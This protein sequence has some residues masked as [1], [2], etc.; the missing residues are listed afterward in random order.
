[1]NKIYSSPVRVCLCAG[2]LILAGIW[3]FFNLPVAMFPDSTRPMIYVN[4][5]F[6]SLPRE[7]FLNSYGKFI[8]SEFRSIQTETCVT[9]EVRGSYKSN[10]V[11]YSLSFRWENSGD[12]CLREVNQILNSYKS[13]WTDEVRYNTYAYLDVMGSGFLHGSFHSETRDAQEIYQRIEPILQPRLSAISEANN[14]SVFN[15]MARQITIELLPLQMASFRLLPKDVFGR[16]RDHL[17]AYSGG[18]LN[19]NGNKIAIEISSGLTG[20]R[21]LENILISGQKDRQILLKHIAK[22]RHE[23]IDQNR[24]ILKINGS[25]SVSVFIQPRPG[26]NI[27]SMSEKVIHAVNE[28]LASEECPD[29]IRFSLSINPAEFIDQSISNVMQEVWLCALIAV[30]VLFLFIGSFSGTL[31]ALI[32]IP[33]SLILSFIVMK[34]TGVQ[35]NLISLGG[36]ALSVGMNVDASIVVIDSIIRKFK[37]HEGARS[38]PELAAL[39]SDAVK[40][41][42]IPVIVSTITSLI[43][44]VPLLFTSDLTNAILGDLAKAVIYSHAISMFIALI[45]V[46][47]IRL[48]IAGTFGSFSEEHRIGWLS[49]ALE[50]LYRFY[51][52]SLFVFLRAKKIRYLSYLLT[53]IAMVFVISVLPGKL[54]RE[55][56]GKP[57]TPIVTANIHEKKNTA[58][59]EME[60]SVARF[61]RRVRERFPERIRFTFTN[62]YGPAGAFFAIHLKDKKE[63][64]ST[65]EQL[66]EMT[67]EDLDIS[68][69]FDSFNP[70]ELPV[71]N[72]PDWRFVFRGQN[73]DDVQ[74]V[75]AA[76]RTTLLEEKTVDDVKE[77]TSSPFDNRVLL[78]PYPEMWNLIRLSHPGLQERDL[79]D[80]ISLATQSVAVSQLIVNNRHLPIV[81][82]YPEQLISGKTQI[83]ALPVPLGE[84]IVP[85]R[86][87]VEISTDRQPPELLRIDGQNMFKTEGYFTEKEKK[88]EREVSQA[89]A[90]VL[91]SF[92]EKTLPDISDKVTVDSEDA[93]TELSKALDELH[94]ALLLSVLLIFIILVVQFSSLLHALIIMLAIPFGIVGVF[95]SLFLF[96]STLSLNSALGIILLVGITV[97]NSIMLVE[98]IL[99]LIHSG[100]DPESAIR[101]T[102]KAR[103]R[104]ILMTS[105][106][107]ILGMLPVAVG[108]G[109]G[110][111]VLQPLGIAVCGGLWVSL[112]FTLYMIPALEYSY[113]KRKQKV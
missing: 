40:D 101:E 76:F 54:K 30:L 83:A 73:P 113:L 52:N 44:F 64:Q 41:V 18:V 45:L 77:E 14:P 99:K 17:V 43:V 35:I 81:A 110:G 87:L 32:E 19:E 97:A 102:A 84:Q 27:K 86:A 56:I 25:S 67:K 104:P 37:A 42:Y 24:N 53:G 75:Q 95:L 89:L 33:T 29:D 71:P 8:E 22:V 79:A 13:K 93:K 20:V 91:Q 65:L 61:E 66:Q 88:K 26:Q 21:S 68:Y 96:D 57:D 100:K 51:E 78:T 59:H 2:V 34:L 36:L 108:H 15:P 1:M 82:R 107:T 62:I 74:A 109:E 9:D 50:A 63:F 23:P 85:L 55:I 16:I 39:V 5:P 12:H 11:Y 3:S 98:M 28:T 4:I 103:I 72:P 7:A 38:F 47:T 46:P 80:I 31:T 48:Y 6:G 60:E 94:L 10:R 111:K 106:T 92:K 90:A 49:A 70:A 105:M 112:I 58:F 69:H